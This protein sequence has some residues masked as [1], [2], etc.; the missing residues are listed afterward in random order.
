MLFDPGA[1]VPYKPRRGGGRRWRRALVLLIGL[2]L[3]G[4]VGYGAYA[5]KDQW[6]IADELDP[7]PPPPVEDTVSEPSE[8]RLEALSQ[9]EVSGEAGSTVVLAVRAMGHSSPM[10]DSSVD[11]EASDGDAVLAPESVQSDS[12]GVARTELTLPTR[13][14][15][16]SVSARLAQSD[17]QTSFTIRVLPGPPARIPAIQGD[18]QR[19]EVE[20][21][22]PEQVGVIVTDA[23]GNPVPGVDVRF[24]TSGGIV[25]P[26]RTRTDS[27]GLATTRWRLGPESGPQRVQVRVEALDTTITLRS[28]ATA[29]PV[30]DTRPQPLE[31]L[32][33]TVVRREFVI[34][35]SHVCS[36]AGEAVSCRGASVRG[37][38]AAEASGFVSLATGASHVCG[39]DSSGR[40]S[41]WGANE[42]GQLGDGTRS[43][44][45]APVAVRTDQIRFSTL[46][47]GV[48]H[49]CGLAGGGVPVCWGQNLNGQVGDGS[50]V[51]RLSPVTVGGGMQF[52]S[53]V[54]GWN[55]TCGLSDNG[56]AFCWGLN[57]DGQLGDGSRLDRLIPELVRAAINSSLAAGSAHTCGISGPQVLCWGKNDSGQLGDGTTQGRPQPGAVQGLP[58]PARQLA[59]GAVHTCA[60]MSD[61]SVYCWG[62]NLHGQL[63]NGSM[64]NATQATRV[65]GDVRFS[66][67]HAGGALTCGWS[68]DGSQYCWG[69]NQYGQLGDGTRQSR[70][71]PTPVG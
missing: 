4:G 20:E 14:G 47:A 63:G 57:S 49:T 67:I 65:A 26:T 12:R 13:A 44:R 2:S 22:L 71:T 21:L 56:N 33:V 5:T 30:V 52:R 69:L 70:S 64:Q 7:L 66:S 54:A 31:T 19:A 38:G 27:T 41:C 58:G 50:R 39:L 55:H 9:T 43:D 68:L 51:D 34:G 11:F 8:P 60:L 62:Q 46:T 45:P 61:G 17:L 32:P 53:L 35:T 37:Q 25:G 16:F 15:S 59:A 6:L 3:L 10:V 29:R 42:G 48:T 18:G 24:S 1:Y 36:L 23:E 28:T 40:A